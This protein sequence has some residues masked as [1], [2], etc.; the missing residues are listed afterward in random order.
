MT[1]DNKVCRQQT[2]TIPPAAGGK[3][4]QP[5]THAS[6]KWQVTYSTLRNSIEGYNG[7]VKDNGYAALGASDKRRIRGIAA[8][9]VFSAMCLMAANIRKIQKF[10][11]EAAEQ[12]DGTISHRKPV[13]RRAR[14]RQQDAQDLINKIEAALPPEPS[15]PTRTPARPL[16]V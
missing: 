15:G 11:D 8:T 4:W 6:D 13:R 5:L 14:R 16:R 12:S 1:A 9:T 10:L 2:I 3:F 7:Y